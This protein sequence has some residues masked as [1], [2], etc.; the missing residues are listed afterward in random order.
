MW[1]ACSAFTSRSIV[2]P[3]LAQPHNAWSALIYM[4]IPSY[5]SQTSMSG[6]PWRLSMPQPAKCCAAHGIA[7]RRLTVPPCAAAA[8][9]STRGR[10]RR[11]TQA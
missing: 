3:H 9:A 11:G 5:G 7:G 1:A 8:G 10:V 2:T 4:R 6:R